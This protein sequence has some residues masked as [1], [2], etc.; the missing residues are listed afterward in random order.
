ML[1]RC[2]SLS[3]TYESVR[4]L[5]ISKLG[6]NIVPLCSNTADEN[7]V[8]SPVLIEAAY[9]ALL[10]GFPGAEKQTTQA[11]VVCSYN[12]EFER[13]HRS[14]YAVNSLATIPKYGRTTGTREER[15]AHTC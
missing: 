9:R 6:A 8:N 4:L 3:Y 13:C 11:W 2:L 5:I 10:Q 7:H 1:E 14:K 12:I 15:M